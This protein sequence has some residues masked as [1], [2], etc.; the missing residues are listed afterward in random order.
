[1][2]KALAFFILITCAVFSTGCGSSDRGSAPNSNAPGTTTYS[3]SSVPPPST[4]TAAP[5]GGGASTGATA[6]KTTPTPPGIKPPTD[7]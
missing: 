4:T 1:M 7:K 5:S 2:R 3:N 6:P